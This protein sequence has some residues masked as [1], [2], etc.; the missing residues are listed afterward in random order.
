MGCAFTPVERSNSLPKLLLL[1][2]PFGSISPLEQLTH[3][4]QQKSWT[5]E[6]VKQHCNLSFYMAITVLL[7]QKN[8]YKE[9]EWYSARWFIDLH[10]QQ[11][12]MR[13]YSLASFRWPK[14]PLSWEYSSNQYVNKPDLSSYSDSTK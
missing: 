9:T 12:A 1:H 7:Q 6:Q 5:T 13:G 3:P 10:T 4:Y 2:F 14:V 11:A 8:I